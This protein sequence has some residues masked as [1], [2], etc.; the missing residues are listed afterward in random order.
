ML[1]L[2]LAAALG[3]GAVLAQRS[4]QRIIAVGDLHGDY[5]AWSA[6]AR[7]AGLVDAR[8]RWRGGDTIM[9]QVGDVPD[10]GPNSLKI[11]RQLMRLQREAPRRGGRVIALVGNHEAMN[12]THDLRYVDPGEYAAFVDSDSATRR[13]R[14]FAANR[15]SIAARYRAVDPRMTDAAIRERWLRETP[16]GRVEHELAWRPSGEIG[17]WVLRNPAIVVVDGNLFVHGG[18][19]TEYS[20]LSAAEINRRTAAALAARDESPGA[21][22]NDPLGPLWYRG[23]VER[24]PNE[25]RPPVEQELAGVLA[26]HGAKRIIVGHTPLPSGI[27]ILYG[28]RLVRIDTGISRHYG[29]RLSYLEIAGD[30]LIPHSL[31]RSAR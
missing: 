2:C 6:I 22:I 5:D 18:I 17:R 12:M 9:V 30:R 19:S 15:V 29:G 21:I 27:A 10:R 11:I 3:G 28:G 13:E 20:G 25:V 16:L 31:P 8:G 23:L 4:A 7:A 14:V 26:A 24:D 1:I